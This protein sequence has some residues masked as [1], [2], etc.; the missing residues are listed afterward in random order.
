MNVIEK[1]IDYGK[2]SPNEFEEMCFELILRHGFSKVCWRQ[3]GADN[4]RDIEATFTVNNS[5]I[6]QK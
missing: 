3:G 6:I 2:I 1:H 4:G 5:L